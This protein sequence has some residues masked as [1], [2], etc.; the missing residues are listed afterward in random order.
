MHVHGFFWTL[1]FQGSLVPLSGTSLQDETC[2]LQVAT[3]VDKAL[4]NEEALGPSST[5]LGCSYQRWV[6]YS[7]G[8]LPL[9]WTDACFGSVTKGLKTPDAD[10]ISKWKQAPCACRDLTYDHI[11]SGQAPK[12]DVKAQLA[13]EGNSGIAPLENYARSV[14]INGLLEKFLKDTPDAQVVLLG[15]GLDGRFYSLTSV[16]QASRLF[17]VDRKETQDL[18]QALVQSCDLKPLNKNGVRHIPLDLSQDNV[19]DKLF[20]DKSFDSKKPT[21]FVAEAVFQYVPESGVRKSLKTLA[22][23]MSGNPASRLIVQSYASPSMEGV[24]VNKDTIHYVFPENATARN[25]LYEELGLKSHKEDPDVLYHLDFF[26][27]QMRD[28]PF[29]WEMFNPGEYMDV[30][31]PTKTL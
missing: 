20:Q 7:Q 31:V 11:V 21:I 13:V 14:V 30:L 5:A 26:Q 15:A 10:T 6:L 4:V 8:N 19:Y 27:K 12:L 25:T 22:N 1:A 2:L 28:L 16:A 24:K 23:A 17:E 3:T 29:N 18:K 9:S